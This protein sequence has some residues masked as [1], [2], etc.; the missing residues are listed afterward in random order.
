MCT[1]K[2]CEESRS[3]VKCTNHQTNKLKEEGTQEYF[4]GYGYGYV[5]YLDGDGIMGVRTYPNSQKCTH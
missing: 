3:H 5:Y 4:G 2:N 1:W